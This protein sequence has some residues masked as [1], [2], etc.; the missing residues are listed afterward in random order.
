[1]LNRRTL[2]A[3]GLVAG[4][5]GWNARSFA[6]GAGVADLVL[7]N[8]QV[9]TGEAREPHDG[10]VA[11]S[12]NRILAVGPAGGASRYLSRSTRTVD[13]KRRFVM[14]GFND[15]HLHLSMMASDYDNVALLGA[16]S[17]SE[18][19]ARIAQRAV[20]TPT[21]QWILCRSQ[22]HEALLREHR[23]PTRDDLDR[24]APQHPVYVPRGGH[25]ATCNSLALKLAGVTRDTPDP[26]GGIIVRDP[27]GEPTGL[28]LET[29][30]S[31]VSRLLPA[32]GAAQYRNNLRRLIAELNSQGLTS[33]TNPSTSAEHAGHFAELRQS[34]GLDVRIS[35]TAGADTAEDVR[36]LRRAHAP[37]EGDDMLRFLGIGE[38]LVDGGVEGALLRDPYM[39]I[40]GEQP[41]PRYRGVAMP[42]ARDKAA[43]TDF[44]REAIAAGFNVMTHATG[45]AGLDV[46][47]DALESVAARQSF[48]HLRWSIH[49]VFLADA[50]Q[51]ERIRRLG[52]QI[53]AQAQPYLLGAQ[54]ARWW[55]RERV[56]RCIPMR[57]FL[58]AGITVGAGSDAPAGIAR[59]MESL[60][61][62]VNRRCLGG[63]QLD[64]RWSISTAEALRLYT[65]G[66]AR[67]QFMDRQLGLLK[68][69]YLA[70]LAV[71]NENPLRV[72]PDDLGRVEV[73]ATLVDGRAVFD[74][75][76]LLA[77]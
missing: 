69:G 25:V 51:I 67:T 33:F 41:D 77:R 8:A 4:A 9:W 49:G 28:L 12:G 11:I 63:V 36:A 27:K 50:A 20:Q 14:P 32:T 59:P 6:K 17:I 35:W 48:R 75:H 18:V 16:A 61:W 7:T 64:R 3:G 74:R 68:R 34:S 37:L 73:D 42:W 66:T 26:P 24:A 21:G 60:A 57:A 43:F 56:D 55:G 47:L 54:I 40:P 39:V 58:D 5:A 22:W 65:L 76:A 70:D 19:E 10:F 71:L 46:C 13:L 72:S 23:M 45:D 38:T 52:M 1:M 44:Y 31:L 15:S 53:T 30:K 29:A 62:M 2:L